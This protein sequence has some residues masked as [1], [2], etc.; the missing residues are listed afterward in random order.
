MVEFDINAATKKYYIGWTDPYPNLY[1]KISP[2]TSVMRII[3]RRVMLDREMEKNT[4]YEKLFPTMSRNYKAL[5]QL[6]NASYLFALFV[7]DTYVGDPVY[8][9][10]VCFTNMHIDLF[11]RAVPNKDMAGYV[12]ADVSCQYCIPEE[13]FGI[14][15]K[16]SIVG[17]Y[18][19]LPPMKM[20]KEQNLFSTSC[21]LKK[22][23]YERITVQLDENIAQFFKIKKRKIWGIMR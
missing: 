2:L 17:G 6:G 15:Y 5:P 8:Q 12:Y 18:F 23:A 21:I 3:G 10:E 9:Q 4:I 22:E 19:H 1:L 20:D 7:D 13:L 16:N 11:V 14:S